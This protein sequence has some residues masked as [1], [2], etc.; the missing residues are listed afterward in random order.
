M[1]LQF[2]NQRQAALGNI[3]HKPG[4]TKRLPAIQRGFYR[5]TPP[6]PPLFFLNKVSPSQRSM[7]NR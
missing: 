4:F 3:Q 5:L 1:Y 6:A 7:A 2:L